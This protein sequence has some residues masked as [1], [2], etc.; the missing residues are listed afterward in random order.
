M[1]LSTIPLPFL[2]TIKKRSGN[3]VIVVQN[4]SG[5]ISDRY[6]KQIKRKSG[7][8][9]SP[10]VEECGRSQHC[11]Y[12]QFQQF[13]LGQNS[14]V[15]CNILQSVPGVST[16]PHSLHTSLSLCPGCEGDGSY[17]EGAGNRECYS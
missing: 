3:T 14:K 16:Y 11:I 2:T 1:Y 12:L 5:A 4:D 7:G 13:P 10:E 17:R 15:L 6:G 9:P 8:K